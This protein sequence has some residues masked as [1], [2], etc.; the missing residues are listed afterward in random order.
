V[1]V[2]ESNIAVRPAV[3]Q[4]IARITTIY[5]AG[6]A[7]R[8]ATFETEPRSEAE[9]ESWLNPEKILLVAERE[10]QVLG[11]A[12]VSS[13]RPRECYKGIGEYSVYVAPEVQ[14]Q[15]VGLVLLP[16][17]IEVAGQHGYWKILSR[18]FPENVGSLRLCA[19]CGFREV[20]IYEKHAK[21]D[22]IWKDVIIVERLIEENLI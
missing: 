17:L 8:K 20:G 9:I 11:W 18:I 19:R 5:N 7:S 3:Q 12:S 22:G 13:Y 10:G 14:G 15:G 16:R 1:P 6:I 21:L 2:N 4:D